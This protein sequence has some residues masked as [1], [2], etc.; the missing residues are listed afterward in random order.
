MIG[1]ILCNDRQAGHILVGDH[2]CGIVVRTAAPLLGFTGISG[3]GGNSSTQPI[4][5]GNAT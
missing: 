3:G 2:S 5:L 4:A 1:I